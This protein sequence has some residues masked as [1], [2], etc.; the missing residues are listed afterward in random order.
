M[1]APTAPTVA[2]LAAEA[3]KKAGYAN[4]TTS[5]SPLTRAQTV[6][7]EEIKNDIWTME[8]KL[9]ALQT[10]AIAITDNGIARM[11]MPSDF[12][13]MTSIE[14]LDGNDYGTAQGGTTSSITLEA[15]YT[16]SAGSLIG[17]HILIYDGIGK[18]SFSQIN[19]YNETTK[20]ASVIPNFTTAPA[21]SDKYLIVDSFSEL[22]Q[23]P[24]FQYAE[25]Y[26]KS[27]QGKPYEYYPHGDDDYGELILH[28][29]P[30]RS[31]EIPYGVRMKYYANLLTVDLESTL[32][33]TLLL[34][35][36][37]VFL[38]GLYAKALSDM[39]D[40]RADGQLAL[41][42]QFIK[43]LPMR[44]KYGND[45]SELTCKVSDY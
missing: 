36:R 6:W 21:S 33:A 44:E 1:A 32:H 14:I 35:W 22:R 16:A 13:S 15:T 39:D 23:K 31:T 4:P 20:V 17:K 11:T 19:A 27:I 38:Q 26:N 45:L 34:R 12:S 7:I 37:N 24:L 18:N 28:P 43:G 30:F 10:E 3:L 41:Y 9:T 29:A 42:M 40:A 5:N 2:T 25:V 8:K